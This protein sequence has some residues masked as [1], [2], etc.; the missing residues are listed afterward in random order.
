[1]LSRL[2]TMTGIGIAVGMLGSPVIAQTNPR[3][4]LAALEGRSIQDSYRQFFSEI[5][6][7]T[8]TYSGTAFDG[9]YR[10]EEDFQLSEDLEVVV[11]DT[12]DQETIFDIS[13]ESEVDDK[14]KVQYELTD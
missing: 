1:M 8:I 3:G 4:N 7:E 2:L 12:L 11:G 9:I 10:S 13:S 14:F 6:S 5:D